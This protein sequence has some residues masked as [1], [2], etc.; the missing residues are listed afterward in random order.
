MTSKEQELWAILDR[1]RSAQLAAPYPDAD[2]RID[3]INRVIAL[4]VDNADALTEATVA[5]FGHRCREASAYADIAVPINQLKHARSRLK[6]WMRPEKHRSEFPFGLLGA[7]ARVEFQP[8]GVIGIIAPWNFPIQLVIGPLAGILAAGNRAMIKPSEFS[9]ATS[10]LMKRLFEQAFNQDE[11]AVV[12]GGADTGAAF[13]SLPFDHLIFTGSP[14]VAVHVAHAAAENL[15]PLTLELGGKSPVILGRSVDMKKA[16]ARIMNGKTLNA[17]QIC[18]SPDYLLIPDGSVDA[19]IDASRAAI[20]DMFPSGLRD[21]DDYTSIINQ[22]HFDRLQGYLND[23]REKGAETIELNPRSES[24]EQQPHHKIP[25]TLVLNPTDEMAIMQHEIFGPLLP[26]MNY[27]DVDEAIEYVN[28]HPRPLAL[29]Y[30]GSDRSEEDRVIRNTTSGGVT[31]N[32]VIL[33]V[34]QEDLPIGGIGNSGTGYYHGKA[35]FLEFSHSRSVFRQT[36]SEL[37]SILRPPFGRLIRL[38]L[39]NRIKK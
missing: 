21:N 39:A 22:R 24:F 8:K 2:T 29:Y 5:D 32:D 35:G 27:Q 3:R 19:F 36:G 7:R 11:I 15:V 30:F 13:S 25:P 33:H 23:A 10:A 4:L 9:E 12:T 34:I 16:A 37:I 26:I 20:N 31:V 17:G 28:N 1:Q 18:L 38:D 6:R 14:P